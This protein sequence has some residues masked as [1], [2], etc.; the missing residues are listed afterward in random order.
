[1]L[2]LR[3]LLIIPAL[4]ALPMVGLTSCGSSPPHKK[5]AAAVQCGSGASAIPL[6]PSADL[7]PAGTWGKAPT[8]KVPPGSPPDKLECAQLISGSGPGAKDGDTLNMEYVLATYSS[9]GVVQSSW[10]SAPF[11]FTLGQQPLI[12]GWVD[13]VIGMQAGSR[14]ELIIPPSLGYGAIS[15]GTGISANDTLVF[16]LDL[17]SIT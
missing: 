6:I 2:A 15:P 8:V 4:A 3:R 12:Q 17:Q 16:V 5:A 1:M 14:R 9:G 13:G 11:S 10:T 7:S